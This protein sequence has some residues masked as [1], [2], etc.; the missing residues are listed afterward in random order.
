VTKGEGLLEVAPVNSYR[1]RMLV[2]ES[3]I[4]DV[5]L[6]QR[7]TLYLSALPELSFPF[8]LSKVT[9]LTENIDG[10]TYFV[11]EGA[12]DQ[13]AD[14]SLIQPGMEGIGKIEVDERLLISIWTREMLE[15]IRLRIWTWWG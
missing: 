5:N 2:K 8:Q 14:L 4:A 12:I 6:E 1:I 13:Q 9:P 10:A 3:R 7:G 15:W 11:I